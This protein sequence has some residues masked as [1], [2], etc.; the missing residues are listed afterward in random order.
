MYTE[1]YFLSFSMGGSCVS[2]NETERED[3]LVELNFLYLRVSS[4]ST[5]MWHLP[6]DS[7]ILE[8]IR[9]SVILHVIRG[10][11]YHRP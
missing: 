11:G 9:L 4:V 6:S 7:F 1:S 3:P 10:A 5:I 2:E 8:N